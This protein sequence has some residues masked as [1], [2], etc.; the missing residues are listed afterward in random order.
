MLPELAVDWLERKFKASESMFYNT[1]GKCCANSRVKKFAKSREI[2]NFTAT[3]SSND[4]HN[5]GTDSGV[6]QETSDQLVTGM[7]LVH[8]Y[9]KELEIVKYS[10]QENYGIMDLIGNSKLTLLFFYFIRDS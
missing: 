2:Y 10:K 7:S 4:T 8:V 1:K 6:Q 3:S 5:V 9:F